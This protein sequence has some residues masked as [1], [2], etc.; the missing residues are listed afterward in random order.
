M[1]ARRAAAPLAAVALVAGCGTVLDGPGPQTSQERDIGDVTVVELATSGDLIVIQ[2]EDARLTITAGEEVIDRLTSDV[3]GDTLEL[4]VDGPGGVSGEIRYEL[5]VPRLE[6]VE[7]AGS[8]D[9]RLDDVAVGDALTLTV[10]GSGDITAG[11]VDVQELTVTVSGSGD[12]D[13]EGRAEQQD[14]EISGSGDYLAAGL[15]S[16]TARISVEG[17]GNAD[18]TVSDRL[19]ASVSGSG[20][21]TY[22]GDPSVDSRIDGSGEIE[23]R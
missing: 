21:V 1:N 18:V 3:D 10:A 11:G 13:V 2:G 4:G 20:N 5:V 15:D 8:G 22:G 9:V 17:S 19:E 7:L 14:V 12:V 6:G 23:P 16:R